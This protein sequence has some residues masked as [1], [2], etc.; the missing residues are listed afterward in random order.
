MEVGQANFFHRPFRIFV[1]HIYKSLRALY[2]V[3]CL[4]IATASLAVRM[5]GANANL[6]NSLKSGCEKQPI[7]EY[8]GLIFC[9]SECCR[10]AR[11]LLNV[12][13]SVCMS[14]RAGGQAVS[15]DPVI[16]F[17]ARFHSNCSSG[18]QALK[19]QSWPDRGQPVVFIHDF[20]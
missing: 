20:S 13:N 8:V 18:Q 11:K 2:T 15:P 7:A 3:Q 16:P 6:S 10:N 19:R 17:I 5:Q 12:F 1:I 14:A 4:S 9:A